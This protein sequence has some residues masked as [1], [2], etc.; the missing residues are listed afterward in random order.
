MG[1]GGSV[2][3]IP[4]GEEK[5]VRPC[6]IHPNIRAVV[7]MHNLRRDEHLEMCG[8]CFVMWLGKVSIETGVYNQMVGAYDQLAPFASEI[9]AEMAA[10]ERERAESVS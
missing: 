2:P 10:R 5:I 9:A 3:F 4:P 6:R 1:S 7:D 8:G